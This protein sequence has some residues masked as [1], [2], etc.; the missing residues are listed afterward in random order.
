[1]ANLS[2]QLA[3]NSTAALLFQ[4]TTGVSPDH[5][6]DPANQFFRA[7][8]VNDPIPILI[9]N[10]GAST[11]YLGG[12]TVT[13]S[14]GV[15]LTANNSVAYNVAGNDSLYGVCAANSTSTV[16]ITVGRQ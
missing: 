8:T 4:T 3:S 16:A 10:A 14:T 1:M 2:V 11:V 15:P 7:A 9:E 12:S 5:A 13:S 6:V